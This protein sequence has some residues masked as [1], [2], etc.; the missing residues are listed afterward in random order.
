MDGVK[1]VR[2]RTQTLEP[3]CGVNKCMKVPEENNVGGASVYMILKIG[4][5]SEL[6]WLDGIAF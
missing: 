6:L 2:S 1:M 3:E 5:F 4:L